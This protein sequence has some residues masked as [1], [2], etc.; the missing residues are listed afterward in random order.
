MSYYEADAD[1]IARLESRLER[2]GLPV[3]LYRKSMAILNA[4]EVQVEDEYADP[5]VADA[6]FEALLI[7][8]RSTDSDPGRAYVVRVEECR[9]HIAKRLASRLPRLR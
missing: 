5:Q 2:V 9:A 6:L 4:I 1:A 8:A 3:V 7:A